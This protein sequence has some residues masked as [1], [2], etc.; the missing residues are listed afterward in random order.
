M[1]TCYYT[2]VK[3]HRMYNTK[4]EP[5][6]KLQTLGDNNVL[7]QAQQPLWCRMSTV[8]E[9][10]HVQGWGVDKNNSSPGNQYGTHMVL[11]LAVEIQ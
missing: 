6:P 10:M 8:G 9:A 1:T 4:S 11:N 2:S 3:T 7:M 5:Y